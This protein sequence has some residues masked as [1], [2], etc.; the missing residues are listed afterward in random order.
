MNNPTSVDPY[1]GNILISGLGPLRS[2]EDLGI[3]LLE[4]PPY[5]T[6][7]IIDL[8][9][10]V[11]LHFLLQ[12]RDLHVPFIEDMRLSETI[13]MMVRQ[14]YH[15]LNPKAAQTWATVS[16][17]RGKPKNPRAP[18]FGGV[19]EG[20]SGTG[21]TVSIL[22]CMNLYPSQ[23]IH[24]KSFPHL[25]GSHQQVVWLSVDVPASGKST[26]LAAALM[27]E[28]DRVTAGNRFAAILA[29][30]RRDGPQML[31]EWRQVASAHF[32][33]IL[34]IDEVQN[35][36][37][38]ATLRKRKSRSSLLEAPELSIVEDKALKWILTLMNTWHIPIL[39]SGTPDGIGAISR[40]LSNTE[41]I[42]TSGYHLFQNFQSTSDLQF[43]SIFLKQLGKYQYVSKRLAVNM[44]LA[45]L[46]LEFTG[47]IQ[48]LIIALWIAAH[49]VAFERNSGDLRLDDFKKAAATYLAPVGPAVA[50]LRSNDPRRMSQYEDLFPRD[51]SFWNQFWSS[52]SRS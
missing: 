11:K 30:N 12:L 28:F 44:E 20:I 42:V 15:Y 31:D 5:P 22:R 3:Q 34:H 14:N 41:R 52:I 26:D 16:G 38:L 27:I 45:E 40:R 1:A 9:A 2:R 33:G 29:K 25:L 23:I 50:A 39:M 21:K 7:A 4:L 10:H 46:I 17:D 32:L 13:D 36:F 18:P 49:R 51:G 47:G 37:K 43:T 6:K 19:V 8:P 24:H 35:F 48:R